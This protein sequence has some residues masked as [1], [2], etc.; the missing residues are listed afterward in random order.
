MSVEES[1]LANLVLKAQE[2]LADGG[3]VAV[4]CQ[5]NEPY[6]ET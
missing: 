6:R 3:S 5:E 1:T 2:G 4:F